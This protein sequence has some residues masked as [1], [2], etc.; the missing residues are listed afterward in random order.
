[1]RWS[2]RVVRVYRGLKLDA[3]ARALYQ[4]GVRVFRAFV[5]A[6]KGAEV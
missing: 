4:A 3:Q 6:K 5:A 1:M 2:L